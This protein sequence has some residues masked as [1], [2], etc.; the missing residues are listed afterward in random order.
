MK[1]R[2]PLYAKIVLWFFLNLLF[3]GLVFY[4]FF[5][6]QFRLGLDSLLAG[7]AGD[8]IQAVSE[9][10][11][12]Q[13]RQTPREQW[14]NLLAEFAGAYRVDFY[15]FQN[16]G[17][18]L[19][20]QPIALPVEVAA[21]IMAPGQRPP[22]RRPPRALQRR[23][24]LPPE[25]Y[26]DPPAIFGPPVPRSP[27]PPDQAGRP[28]QTHPKQMIQTQNPRR[29][30]VVVRLPMFSWE[31]PPSGPLN[32]VAVSNSI[33]GAGLFFDYVPWLL[34]GSAVLTLSVL[35][36]FPLIRGITRSI[37]QTTL[38]TGRIAEGHFDVRVA[39]DRNDEL[40]MLGEAVNRM[41]ARLSGFVS[42]Q[43]RFL[44]DIA[45]ELCSPIARIQIAIGI[46][47]QHAAGK[48]MA[49]VDDVREEIQE[50]SALVNELL[51]FS[52]AGLM[53]GSV[54]LRAVEVALLL[55]RII[56]RETADV[57]DIQTQIEPQLK[58][59]AEPEL[60]SRAL[61]NLLRNAVRY[62]ASAGAITVSARRQNESV[63]VT[64][65]DCG[66]GVP[67]DTLEQIFDPFF[68]VESSRSRDTGGA[69]LGLAIVKTCIEACGG[70]VKAANRKPTGLQVELTLKAADETPH[71]SH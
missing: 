4:A 47:E 62:A 25:D 30:W 51:S 34:I 59:L 49:Y 41:A 35:V 12:S 44:G 64:V 60:L 63:I 27:A 40:G 2:F 15:L 68:R 6:I 48:E 7:R 22:D 46:L 57:P 36:W 19:A 20:G 9:I 56:A 1:I 31:P 18:Q 5:R 55:E 11:V 29:Y 71:S 53:R 17:V 13:L 8:H 43:K 32:L 26:L 16:N 58:A 45:H 50:M 67:Q 23:G 37:S 54:A 14:S 70:T 52:K 66:P 3:L 39:T 21:R 65:A 69:G 38:A 24:I 28:R 61:A 33:R 42:G 10:I